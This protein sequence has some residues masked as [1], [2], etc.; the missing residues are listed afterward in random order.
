MAVI[1]RAALEMAPVRENLFAGLFVCQSHR[2]S[3]IAIAVQIAVVQRE[4]SRPSEADG[5][6][7]EVIAA[8]VPFDVV[9]KMIRLPAIAFVKRVFKLRVAV[10][11]GE[12]LQGGP[13]PP[14]EARGDRGT[15]PA[16]IT[17]VGPRDVTTFDPVAGEFA[18]EIVRARSMRRL[19]A[20]N[21]RELPGPAVIV[22]RDR[23]QPAFLAPTQRPVGRASERPLFIQVQK[24]TLR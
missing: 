7:N 15:V 13:R 9:E 23:P 8:Q 24:A 2:E 14:L 17:R 3:L 4:T 22:E 1:H 11:F 16:Q 18:E 20:G 5:V 6:A 19:A 10:P 21:H 12:E